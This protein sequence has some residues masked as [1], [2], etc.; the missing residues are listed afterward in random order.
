MYILLL[1]FKQ[2]VDVY[3]IVVVQA[4]SGC[5]FYCCYS[6]RKWMYILL[7]LFKQKVDIYFK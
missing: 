1:L 6:S 7:L 4:E 3:F 5:I 2:K